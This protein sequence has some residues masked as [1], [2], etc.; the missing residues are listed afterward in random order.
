MTGTEIIVGGVLSEALSQEVI[1]ELSPEQ[2]EEAGHKQAP[3]T[4]RGVLTCNR[5]FMSSQMDLFMDYVGEI[6]LLG[7]K[8]TG[9]QF[10]NL[11]L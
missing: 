2:Q 7:I 8:Q 6:T 10:R 11:P 3:L 1:C 4:G 9:T 5:N